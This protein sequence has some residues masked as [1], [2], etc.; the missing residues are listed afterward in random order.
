MLTGSAGITLARSFGPLVG[1]PPVAYAEE[2]DT[3]LVTSNGAAT[4]VPS[5]QVYDVAGAAAA[6]LQPLPAA[7]LGDPGSGRQVG[8][9]GLGFTAR[10]LAGDA[11]VEVYPGLIVTDGLKRR[12]KNFAHVRNNESQTLAAGAPF[13]LNGPEHRH[14]I[15]DDQTRWE[16]TESWSGDL[17]RV[18][19]SS[20]QSYADAPAPI[21]RGAHPGAALDGDRGTSW[22]SAANLEP[23]GQWW[24][25]DLRAPSRV[26]SLR[27]ALAPDSA[28]VEQLTIS[29]GTDSA[30][31]AAP[32]PGQERE[33]TL[34]LDPGRYLRVT[35]AGDPLG[36]P[37]AL[38]ISE[39]ESDVLDAQRLLT[40]PELPEGARVDGVALTRD[41]EP[42]ACGLVAA[43]FVC[44]DALV[45]PGEDGDTLARTF[46]LPYAETFDAT[47]SGSL[48]RTQGAGTALL[49]RYGLSVQAPTSPGSDVASSG[50]A[51]LDD[52]PATT[53]ISVGSPT[54]R[55][56]VG[57]AQP[58]RLRQIQLTVNEGAAASVP[59]VVKVSHGPWSQTVTLDEAGTAR[60]LGP[61]TREFSVRILQVAPAFSVDGRD[62]VTLP[63]GIS[64][65]K[66]NARSP[67]GWAGRVLEFPCGAG[68]VLGYSGELVPTSVTAS[69]QGLIRGEQVA[70][71]PCSGSVVGRRGASPE[72]GQ[73][74]NTLLVRPTPLFRVD[75]VTLRSAALVAS[76][77][78]RVAVARDSNGMPAAV[79]VTASTVPRLLALPQNLNAGWVAT[80]AGDALDE[81]RVDGWRQAWV[82]PAGVGGTIELRFE[83][84]GRF[85]LML[86]LGGGLVLV[87]LLA[88]LWP[89]RRSARIEGPLQTGPPGLLDLAVVLTA[90][91]LLAGWLGLAVMVA[92]VLFGVLMP[93]FAGWPLLGAAAL[94]SASVGVAWPR[95]SEQSWSVEWSQSTSLVALG[96]LVAALASLSRPERPG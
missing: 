11:P 71:T 65:L 49:T 32:E 6:T 34:G 93:A 28:P 90:G 35:G 62:F 61:R 1:A 15:Y 17:T 21:Q 14:R 39:V 20:S 7:L 44:N 77:Q 43:A 53:W 60:L 75:A 55:I 37:G 45:S 50:L 76:G 24:Q 36:L 69:A 83:P 13:R 9:G 16:T 79:Q 41:Q 27:V 31:V 91:G 78:E 8:A 63:P 26:V 19:A 12:E 58:S 59:R 68:P 23:V 38:A 96:A 66:V 47:V 64:E 67:S 56:R 81:Q 54:P 85:S 72:L 46:T 33:Y 94:V 84:Q 80:A 4:H 73:G 29:N 22:R 48:R 52:D 74:E 86:G 95:I 3:R 51:I 87:T 82:V 40:L 42:A 88:A 2:S 70:V 18:F 25:A 89:A 57:L 30:V 5:V 92:A 10:P